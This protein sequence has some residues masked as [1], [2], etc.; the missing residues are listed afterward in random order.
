MQVF[1]GESVLPALDTTPA[2]QNSVQD[3]IH[4]RSQECIV[5][6]FSRLVSTRKTSRGAGRDE[7]VGR[8]GDLVHIFVFDSSE[9]GLEDA[10]KLDSLVRSLLPESLAYDRVPV[11]FFVDK[12]I[13]SAV[14]R[15]T[16]HQLDVVMRYTFAWAKIKATDSSLVNGL[17]AGC[18]KC[19]FG[20]E[21]Y[22]REG[23]C[24]GLLFAFYDLPD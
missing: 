9:N 23:G 15:G 7:Q 4:S 21:E 3:R 20:W 17:K 13:P 2:W 11:S 14:G 10:R 16:A 19:T 22:E 6:F 12:E 1:S 8:R 24:R 5:G 18:E